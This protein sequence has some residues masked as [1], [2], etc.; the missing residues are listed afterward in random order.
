M[1]CTLS[2]AQYCVSFL[3]QWKTC[4][5]VQ[6]IL[7][8]WSSLT[9]TFRSVVDIREINTTLWQNY[10]RYTIAGNALI[11]IFAEI[12]ICLETTLYGRYGRITFNP[13]YV[14]SL[15]HSE[16]VCPMNTSRGKFMRRPVSGPWERSFWLTRER[17]KTRSSPPCKGAE[18][19]W[20]KK[21]SLLPSRM[22]SWHACK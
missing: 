2:A 8:L 21:R 11:L 13:T 6:K 22:L 3:L 16:E 5:P 14:G 4:P 1:T 18:L 7:S 15:I 12:E 9:V 10:T 19:S 17:E 20:H